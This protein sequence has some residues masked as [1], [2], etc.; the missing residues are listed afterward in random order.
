[1]FIT[2][3]QR[4]GAAL[5]LISGLALS[6]CSFA[7]DYKRP[8]MDI[9]E[10]WSKTPYQISTDE[11]RLEVQWWKRFND[12]VLDKL[13]EEALLHNQ[14][15]AEAVARADQARAYLGLARSEYFP[16]IAGSAS[17]GRARLTD[18]DVQIW[19]GEGLSKILSA[20]THQ[21]VDGTNQ[22]NSQFTAAVQAAWEI[23]LWG[24]V[25]NSSAAMREQVLASEA[26]Q[27]GMLLSL[28][29]QTAAAYINLRS[30]DAQL[31]I[32]RRT[33]ASREEAAK[34]YSSRYKIGVISELDY[35]RALTEVDT[36]RASLYTA[37]YQVSMAESALLLLT[38]RSPR[39]IFEASPKR[40]LEIDAIP[41]AP[42]LPVGMPSDLL[43]RRPDLTA[44]EAM[45]KAANFNIG[46]ARA[47]WFPSIS[48]TGQFGSRSL[49]LDE[50]FKSATGIWG[51]GGSINLPLF[52]FGRISNNVKASEA[53][54]REAAAAYT[55][56]VQKAFRDVR[57]ALVVQ[58]RT[59][60]VVNALESAVNRLRTAAR[61]ARLRYDNGY[62][63]YM[64]V[65]D[66]ERSLFGVEIQL[67]GVRAAHLSSIINVCMA[68]G[69]GWEEEGNTRSANAEQTAPAGK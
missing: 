44:A 45:L 66:A 64:D 32:A 30:Y 61:L 59:V 56:A 18:D 40:G 50:L 19:A 15:L 10:N 28:A 22:V 48:L 26:G 52:T 46:V 41:S 47:A 7:P 27:R 39:D 53:A 17:A 1:M 69:G 33:L 25:R 34:I 37:Q 68:L 24:K 3:F 14:N 6:G 16:V 29:G 62:A 65:L 2:V 13:V 4:A 42:Q 60:H 12:P 31:G 11:K 49:E 23:D 9:P 67:A 20:M 38:G 51:L 43:E 5:C 8:E 57:N 36:V 21:H 54:Q 58:E 55:L 35:M 63:S